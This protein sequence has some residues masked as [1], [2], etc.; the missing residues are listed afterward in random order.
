MGCFPAPTLPDGRVDPAWK[1]CLAQFGQTDKA[2]GEV[3]CDFCRGETMAIRDLG[4]GTPSGA[5]RSRGVPQLG[6]AP[7]PTRRNSLTIGG[8]RITGSGPEITIPGTGIGVGV[9]DVLT[10]IDV[11]R[12][13]GGSKPGGTTATGSQ[14]TTTTPTTSQCPPGTLRVPITGQCLDLVPGGEQSGAGVVVTPGEAVVGAF[15]LPAFQPM[16]VGT[17]ANGNVIRRC[18]RRTVLGLDNRCYVKGTIPRQFRKWAPDAKPPVSAFD[19]RMMRKY[20]RGGSKAKAAAKLAR[21]AGYTT[22]QK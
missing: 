17:L 18:P 20:G 4:I 21:E 3:A 7:L 8:T 19:A 9:D 15:G 13:G 2:G 6:A 16:V 1:A 14:L 11:I 5:V 12:G 22:K 10:V